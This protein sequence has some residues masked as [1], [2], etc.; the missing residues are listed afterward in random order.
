ME[1]TPF[2]K[3]RMPFEA[4]HNGMLS[5]SK[6]VPLGWHDASLSSRQLTTDILSRD[7]VGAIVGTAPRFDGIQAT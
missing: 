2:D 6:H 5:S 1:S 4:V 7:R 3:L